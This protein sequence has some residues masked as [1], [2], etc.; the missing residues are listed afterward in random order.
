MDWWLINDYIIY[1]FL[2]IFIVY[3]LWVVKLARRQQGTTK[4]VL[5]ISQESVDLSKRSVE[6]GEARLKEIK[7]TNDLLQQ[8]VHLMQVKKNQ[9]ES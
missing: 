7:K 5:A 9:E 2:V 3:T 4:T 8:L 1:I 6:L